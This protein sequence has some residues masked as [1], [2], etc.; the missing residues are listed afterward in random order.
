M[1]N[2]LFCSMNKL[3]AEPPMQYKRFHPTGGNYL[4][5]FVAGGVKLESMKNNLSAEALEFFRAQGRRGGLKS[6]RARMKK[7]TREERSAI[8]RKAAEA[9]W[10]KNGK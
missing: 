2:F 3:Y 5:P 9:R 1:K 8:A 7:L 10:G 6:K 4:L